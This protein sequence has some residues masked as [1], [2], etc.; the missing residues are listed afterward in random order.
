MTVAE[1]EQQN[2]K[3]NEKALNDK[4]SA[5]TDST[6]AFNLGIADNEREIIAF[7][8]ETERE[9]LALK[10]EALTLK[11]ETERMES[12]AK[13]ETAKNYLAFKSLGVTI[14]GVAVA[15]II[16]I[17][18]I[19][20]STKLVTQSLET[21]SETLRS[22]T[23]TKS[24]VTIVMAVGAIIIVGSIARAHTV[25][26]NNARSVAEKAIEAQRSL[27]ETRLRIDSS[28]KPLAV[29]FYPQTRGTPSHRSVFDKPLQDMTRQF[30]ERYPQTKVS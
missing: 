26:S 10:R 16:V 1:I 19:R 20:E 2:L 15:G 29:E 24:A 23:F 17:V 4:L 14:F 25:H 28:K 13:I 3:S 22:P 30:R 7:W 8:R 11:N 18:I 6:Q 9:D 5:Q 12:A 27:E 21:L